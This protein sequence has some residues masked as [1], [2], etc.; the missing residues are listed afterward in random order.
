MGHFDFKRSRYSKI[1]GRKYSSPYEI[2]SRLNRATFNSQKRSLR[3]TTIA[4]KQNRIGEGMFRPPAVC[5]SLFPVESFPDDEDPAMRERDVIDLTSDSQV[6]DGRNCSRDAGCLDTNGR[7]QTS[8]PQPLDNGYQ[9]T[10]AGVYSDPPAYS[11]ANAIDEDVYFAEEQLQQAYQQHE[12]QRRHTLFIP[13]LG[14]DNN[15]PRIS[16]PQRERPDRNRQRI[17]HHSVQA[18]KAAS[19]L[20]QSISKIKIV[21]E[22]LSRFLA[23][24]PEHPRARE[25]AEDYE[26]LKEKVDGGEYLSS[27]EFKRIYAILKNISNR[28]G[29]IKLDAEKRLRRAASSRQNEHATESTSVAS[30]SPTMSPNG[31]NLVSPVRKSTGGKGVG[32]I[33]RSAPT[34]KPRS[35]GR[36]HP[37]DVKGKFEEEIEMDED[38]EVSETGR[39]SDGEENDNSE[40]EES[41][42]EVDDRDGETKDGFEGQELWKYFVFRTTFG[43]T[44]DEEESECIGDWFN[45]AKA[46]ARLRKEVVRIQRTAS[47][48]ENSRIELRTIIED[49]GFQSQT[50]E[51]ASGRSI[52]LHVDKQMV[53]ADTLSTRDRNNLSTLPYKVYSIME[54]IIDHS[55][56]GNPIKST[57]LKECFVRKSQA[58]EE[59]RRCLLAHLTG[60]ADGDQAYDILQVSTL[61][62]EMRQY[63]QELEDGER[64][65]DKKVTVPAGGGGKEKCV[66]VRVVEQFLRGPRN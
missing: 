36:N 9:G 16:R 52:V 59:A 27:A 44:Q 54:L 62:T 7:Q 57:A 43:Q 33:P 6:L 21:G 45:K 25:E 58:H 41:E 31:A 29:K 47:L 40:D 42:E 50:I 23:Q 12:D 38:G 19:R 26:I 32:V 46:E 11:V 61:E 18:S 49:D 60:E 65:F 53:D 39:G 34:E 30:S 56:T 28:E 51:F 22:A 2:Y 24:N 5:R 66:I 20:E 10:D 1:G 3:D 4:P 63:L 48:Q 14:L 13:G 8:F 15:T 64:L 55:D 37:Q 17:R 35:G